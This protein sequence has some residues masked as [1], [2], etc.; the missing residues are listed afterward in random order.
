MNAVDNEYKKNISEESR[1]VNQIEKNYI[2]LPGGRLDRFATG[3]LQ[4]LKI[5]R[6]YE[7]VK[8]F[9]E[10]NY[11]SNLMSL[12]IVGNKSL[13]KLQKFVV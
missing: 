4:T 2:S 7:E 3:C 9:Y 1:G 11:S 12:V 13:E 5:D 6:I 8:H 10:L